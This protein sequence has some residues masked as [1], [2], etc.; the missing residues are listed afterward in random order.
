MDDLN[1]KRNVTL[2]IGSHH[3]P[4]INAV[5]TKVKLLAND[6][7]FVLFNPLRNDHYI[8]ISLENNKPYSCVI[9]TG[10][11]QVSSNRVQSVWYRWKPE[12]FYDGDSMY[13]TLT[14]D[15]ALEE[16][17]N[18]ILSLAEF[19]S[20]AVWINPLLNIEQI[21]S[22]AFQLRLAQECGLKI[23]LSK[24]TN[25]AAS[26]QSLFSKPTLRVVSKPLTPLLIPPNKRIRPKEISKEYAMA[27]FSRI[28]V[29]PGIFQEMIP[30]GN[31]IR[32]VIVGD[33]IFATRS[34]G[35]KSDLGKVEQDSEPTTLPRKPCKVPEVVENGLLSF[36]RRAGLIYGVYNLVELDDKLF[37]LDCDPCG[38]WLC[39]ENGLASAVSEAVAKTLIG[40]KTK[41]NKMPCLKKI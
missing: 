34:A 36:H 5:E 29:F 22:K 32:V 4:H 1:T 16:W 21:K 11:E 33:V 3:D 27:S 35:T 13:D 23:P 30:N 19:V 28:S 8:D 37:F 40:A 39:L 12:K 7:K 9:T 15:F 25:D 14:K 24:I 6:L 17:K 26:V 38:A 2:C 31:N 10:D 41:R 18:V 20:E